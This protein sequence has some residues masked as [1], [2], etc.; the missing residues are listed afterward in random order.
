MRWIKLFLIFGYLACDY[1]VVAERLSSVGLSPQLGAY[2]L[3]YTILALALFFTAQIRNHL[4]RTLFALAFTAGTIFQQS[5]EWSTDGALT[6]ESFINLYNSRTQAENALAQ[7]GGVLVK[8]L[9]VA[10]LLFF[11]IALPPARSGIAPKLAIFA[12]VAALTLLSSMFYLRGGEGSRALPAAFAPVSFAGLLTLETL[13]TDT[14]P[15]HAVDIPRSNQPVGRDIVL[16]I[17]ESVGGNYLDINNPRGVPTGLL[18]APPGVRIINYGYA[19]SI[20]TCSLNSN[21]GLRYG[22]MRSNYQ[23]TIAR[24]PSIWAY[25]HKAGLRTVYI[26]AQSNRG[27]LQN[28][29]TP[30]ERSEIDDF[31]QF[32]DVPVLERDMR[33]A[34]VLADR[35]NDERSEFI[36]VNKVGAHFPIQNK[37]PDS[38]LHYKPALPRSN[39]LVSSWSSDRTGFNGSPEEWVR[40]RNSYRN[41]LLWNVGEFFSRFLRRA[42]LNRATIIYTSDHGQD[43]HERGNPGKNTHCG[44]DRPLQEEGL[45]PLLV[46]EGDKSKTRDWHRDL[47][48]NRNGMSHFRIFPTLL[49]LMGYEES[50]VR[51]IY[52]APL[53]DPAKDDFSFNVLFNTRLGR[54]PEWETIDRATIVAPPESDWDTSR[55]P[56]AR[57]PA[58]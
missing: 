50:K 3:L 6:Y 7:F 25:A 11:G 1:S 42:D 31:M 52:G 13:L 2:L 21:L 23:D 39:N 51:L 41:T 5:V 53:D 49:S 38:M 10:F 28:L 9:P 40:Y 47:R 30:A 55:V 15:R 56:K 43:L 14:G 32:D 54:K 57:A 17:D 19:A 34:E 27:Q 29:M 46:I 44:V 12:P 36:Y 24:Y 4:V 18:V 26:D 20:H 45:V 8:V 37:Y 58:P 33:I 22:G 35:I 48:V 16:L